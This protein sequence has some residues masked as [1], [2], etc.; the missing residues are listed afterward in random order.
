[1]KT[2]FVC[3]VFL[4]LSSL[5]S[6]QSGWVTQYTSLTK[7]INDVQFINSLTGFAA[8]DTGTVLKTTNGGQNWIQY[9][10]NISDPIYRI[11]FVTE[12]TGYASSLISLGA[13]GWAG[14]MYKTTN[15]GI[16]WYTLTTDQFVS[17]TSIAALNSDTVLTS[18]GTF[19][20]PSSQGIIY[21]TFNGG[22]N[23]ISSNY[24][25]PGYYYKAQITSRS[26]WWIR[27]TIPAPIRYTIIKSSDCGASWNNLSFN[28]N[29]CSNSHHNLT[30]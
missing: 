11:N 7:N 13:S 28:G 10:V 26:S 18:A 22:N 3:A 20:D 1:M 5:A 2:I 9:K 17:P 15:G 12:V 19:F 14:K 30:T 6:A 24:I 27:A 29:N 25:T 23:F 4:L 8:A 21:K 16:N